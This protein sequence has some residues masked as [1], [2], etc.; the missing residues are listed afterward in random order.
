MIYRVYVEKKEGFDPSKA[1]L[2][3]DISGLLKIKADKIRKL[4]RYDVEGL[5]R[6]EMKSAVTS[7]F[8]EP[9]VDRV[10]TE[11]EFRAGRGDSTVLVTEYLEGQF[12][13]RADSAM[14]C[15]QFLTGGTRPLIKCATVY[16]FH[17]IDG[18]DLDAVKKYLINPV[19][20]KEGSEDMPV[21]LKRAAAQTAE[22]R[23]EEKGFNEMSG[24]AL[25]K[26]YDGFGFAMSFEDLLFVQN[27]FRKIKRTPTY[28]ELKVI[29]TYWSDHCR[30]TTFLTKLNSV[31]IESN[32]PDLE[33]AYKQY[34]N[35]FNE[36]YKDRQ[37][38]Y[39]CLMDIATI[40]AKKLRKE[41][42]LDNLDVSDEINA[43]SVV[44]NVDVDGKD[45]EWLIMFKN[46]TH[47]H[48]TEIEPFGGAATCLGGA[49]RD[50][51]SGRTYVYQAMRVTGA[52]N[53]LEEYSK[54]L[55]GK[56]PQRMLTRTALAGFSS[57]GNQIGLATGTVAEIYNDRFK[58][59]R[60]ETGYVIGGNKREN[61]VRRQPVAGDIVIMVGGD[62]G[63]DGCGGA[64]GS[65]KS[66]TLQSI[67][68][69]GAEVQKGN[70]LEE[71]KLQ[72][73]FRNPEVSKL[74]VKCND[75]GAGGVCVAIGELADGL[76]IH[77]ERINKKYDGLSA[78][79]LAISES[80]ERMAVVVAAEDA[81]KFIKLAEEEN[82]KS[83]KVADVTDSGRLRMFYNETP[84]VDIERSFLDTNG[85]RQQTDVVISDNYDGYFDKTTEEKRNLIAAKDYQKLIDGIMSELNV[86]SQ[87][88][89]GEVFDSTI[90][91]ASVLMPFGG[92]TQLT[93]AVMMAAK[94][95]VDGYTTTVTCSSYS[96]NTDLLIH[97]PY[98]GAMYS[99]VTAV[100]KLIAGGVDYSTV[101]LTLQEFF[102]RLGKD[103]KRWGEPTSALLGA[104]DAQLN[105]KLAAIG[106]KDSMSGTFENID[107]PPTLIAFAMGIA[108]EE[109]VIHNAFPAKGRVYLYKVPKNQN[110]R[111]QFE[112]LV[113][114]YKEISD[115][116][117]KKEILYATVVEEGGRIAALVKSLVG[118]RVGATLPTFKEA[119][120]MPA[121]GDV[122]VVSEKLLYGGYAKE[123]AELKEDYTLTLGG[124]EVDLSKTERAFTGTLESVFPTVTDKS[125]EVSPVNFE[126]G[127]SFTGL[128]KCARPKVFIPAF[129]GTNCE[130]DT[131]RAFIR[132][133]ADAEIFVIKNQTPSQLEESIN[134]MAAA[135]RKAQIIAFPGGFSGGDEPD[136]SGKFIVNTFKN[137]VLKERVE[138]LLY[139]RDGLAIGICNGFQALIK[140]GLLP[141]GH[142]EDMKDNSPTLTF[143]DIFRHV[144]TVS[145]VRVG[146]DNSPWLSAL[147]VGEIYSVPVSHGE[148]KFVADEATLKTLI[149]NG[150]I[151][152]QYVDLS[153]NVTM[154]SPYNPNGSTAAIEGIISPDGRILG[155][156]GHA[157][158]CV[159][160][161]YKNVEGNY[162]MRLFESGVKY[163]K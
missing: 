100:S 16:L 53:P 37:D 31:R 86:C 152:T 9:A 20:S 46:E 154:Q 76:D 135:I 123:Y 22:M 114:M 110:G 45:E 12:D 103:P 138:E 108:K 33:N 105:M 62:T 81:D 65:S 78:T 131:A 144:S 117:K 121:Y 39:P 85:V 91:A 2:E 137:P 57:Y 128:Y 29:D 127:R 111:P 163:F 23:V 90:G 68:T 66:H 69:C 97:S 4:L 77:L 140:L 50:P 40:A 21:T 83:V 99:V 58:A 158:R 82:L 63:R 80:Q 153:G 109:N 5:T 124:V 156:M 161:L 129:P 49:I 115:K 18:K 133:G 19:D 162:D 95:P 125:G 148:G 113:K 60:L 75:F 89:L 32:N 118:N 132:A 94:P 142:I 41:G 102:K 96:L 101:R 71:R 61:V 143:N 130:E 150:Q 87:K 6:D 26:Y 52:G 74:I 1:K 146:T 15:V 134:A 116:I 88:G 139:A 24:A 92:K 79:E 98:V 157:E 11:D 43:C 141:Y 3:A 151:F 73:L 104:L 119:D 64:T 112:S 56:L 67:D 36:M 159:K 122:I 47:N 120:V 145:S 149:D 17:G 27:Y 54:T 84:I 126:C 44:V 107:V 93:P 25:K 70:A 35:L 34:V 48:P 147:K 7:V 72:R 55:K 8:S 136:G 42:Y 106:G 160:G 38:K 59:K 14:Q 51:L 30:H 10:Y 28:T 155:K 13:Q